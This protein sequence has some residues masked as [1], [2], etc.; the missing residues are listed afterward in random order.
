M[1]RDLLVGEASGDPVDDA[2][3]PRGEGI[4]RPEPCA[5]PATRAPSDEQ[6]TQQ[7]S[8]PVHE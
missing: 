3:L 6:S 2:A 4:D 1:T 7:R 8:R 5:Q